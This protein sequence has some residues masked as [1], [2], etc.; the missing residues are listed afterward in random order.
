MKMSG[1]NKYLI[2]ALGTFGVA[3]TSVVWAENDET[4][5]NFIDEG[6]QKYS[7]EIQASKSKLSELR[8]QK[9]ELADQLAANEGRDVAKSGDSSV[10]DA[11]HQ[12]LEAVNSNI[13]L[14]ESKIERSVKKKDYLI[15]N[16]QK[17]YNSNALGRLYSENE[18]VMDDVEGSLKPL[19]AEL[20]KIAEN[21]KECKLTL[22][23][24][25]RAPAS[26]SSQVEAF[27]QKLKERNEMEE[28][29]ESLK[30][31]HEAL[32]DLHTIYQGHEAIEHPNLLFRG[33]NVELGK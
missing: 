17:L 4:T 27:K 16:K 7:T 11:R 3:L 10:V 1:T 8:D 6:I 32:L 25:E 21:C 26:R 33:K 14:A 22:L 29:L 15:A 30:I 18:K 20:N 5:T 28:R 19:R 12:N 31:Q 13:S 24:S 9:R 23:A 2:V